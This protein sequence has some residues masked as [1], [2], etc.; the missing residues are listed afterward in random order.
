VASP[1]VVGTPTE[2]ANA[3]EAT[4]NVINHATGGATDL[5]ILVI[6]KGK[7]VSINAHGDWSELLDETGFVGGFYVAYHYGTLGTSSTLVASGVTRTAA[8]AYLISGAEN[9]ATQAPQV[10]T[11]ASGSSTTPDPPTTTPTGGAK[12]YLWI[13]AC[14]RAGEEADDDTW[15]TA[16][17]TNFLPNPPLQKACGIAGTNLG[18]IVAAASFG[19]NAAS[20]N[21]ATF[22][23]ATGAWRA[24]TIAVHPAPPAA[25]VAAP[26]AVHSQAIPASLY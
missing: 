10:G 5:H 19:S 13:A 25:F 17:P 18:G 26:P 4:N 3:T 2:T 11:T 1:A 6:C 20:M 8:I 15:A 23:I 22:T 14:T 9:P 12:D 24:Q 21:P 16:S 7:N